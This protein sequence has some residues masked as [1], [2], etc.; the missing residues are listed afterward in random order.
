[1]EFGVWDLEDKGIN[2][3]MK[4]GG[5]GSMAENHFDDRSA[6]RGVGGFFLS[7]IHGDYSLLFFLAENKL[8]RYPQA[9][10]YCIIYHW[11]CSN[12]HSVSSYA[13]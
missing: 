8:G 11:P 10:I 3:L 2:K 9:M 7:L 6:I 5:E 12:A 13:T 1:M 4:W